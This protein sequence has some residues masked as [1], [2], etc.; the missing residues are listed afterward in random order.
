MLDETLWF[1]LWSIFKDNRIHM[2]CNTQRAL[3][4]LHCFFECFVYSHYFLLSTH[5]R[6]DNRSRLSLLSTF[7]NGKWKFITLRILDALYKVI[8]IIQYSISL[9]FTNI[10]IYQICKEAQ[11]PSIPLYLSS[12]WFNNSH[13]LSFFFY[14]TI[15]YV[16]S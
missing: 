9:Q 6:W 16:H 11:Q 3:M 15:T 10:T 12:S 13:S 7:W 8:V 1:I 2:K 4:M 14:I 5:W